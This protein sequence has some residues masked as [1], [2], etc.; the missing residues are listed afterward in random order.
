MSKINAA[1]HSKIA[2]IPGDLTKKFQPL[3]ISVNKSFKAHIRNKW[4]K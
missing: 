2:V 1:K 4:E 3:N